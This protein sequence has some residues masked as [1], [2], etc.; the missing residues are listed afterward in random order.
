MRGT[1]LRIRRSFGSG[2]LSGQR[3][4]LVQ[5]SGGSPYQLRK[6]SHFPRLLVCMVNQFPNEMAGWGGGKRA[7]RCWCNV[8]SQ[9]V[10]RHTIRLGAAP[11]KEERVSRDSE[12][13]AQV[14]VG[15]SDLVI[16]L[17]SQMLVS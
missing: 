4:V 6:I 2:F 12:L 13:A 10:C 16:V 5:G 11:P 9:T 1:F 14:L 3:F 8:E 7:E 15:A 17:S